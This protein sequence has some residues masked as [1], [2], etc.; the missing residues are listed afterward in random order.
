MAELVLVHG[1]GQNAS[2][3]GRVAARLR[4]GGHTV[5]T[6]DLPK[7]EA[8][9]ALRDHAEVIAAAAVGP[10]PVIVAHSFSGVFLPLVADLRT[11]GALIYFAAVIPAP[12]Q[13]IRA[14]FE[15]D[16]T[17]FNPAWI[18]A[19]K[20]WFEP[21]ETEGLA[22]EFLFHDCDAE[23]LAWG[24]TTME[25]YDTRPLV[26]EASPA[27]APAGVRTAAIVASQ[28]RTI[29]PDWG[30]RMA[31]QLLG[32]EAIELD[33]GH[34]PHVSRAAETTDLLARLAMTDDGA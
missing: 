33:A 26:T 15:A 7:T 12:G 13:S 24:L 4:E 34:C 11:C 9:W 3:W 14:Q 29:D 8:H 20:R 21:D 18:E 32:V 17:M 5:A 27:A 28:D 19:G 22:R 23:T 25:F 16:A 31:R 30:R 1:S 2:S 10:A 6:P